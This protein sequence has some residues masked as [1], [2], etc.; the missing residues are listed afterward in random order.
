MSKKLKGPNS[1]A[2][3]RLREFYNSVIRKPLN[4]EDKIELRKVFNKKIQ[5]KKVAKSNQDIG[6]R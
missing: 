5:I 4:E 6:S 2:A 3:A 1:N